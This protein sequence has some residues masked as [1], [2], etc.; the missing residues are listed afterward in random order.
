MSQ[1]LDNGGEGGAGGG[2]QPMD[3][4]GCS[5]VGDTRVDGEGQGAGRAD[6]A[7]VQQDGAAEKIQRQNRLEEDASMSPGGGAQPVEQLLSPEGVGGG[8]VAEAERSAR[9]DSP[10]ERQAGGRQIGAKRGRDKVVSGGQGREQRACSAAPTPPRDSRR[11]GKA[12]VDYLMHR[13]VCAKTCTKAV[14]GAFGCT[15]GT[16][17]F[18]AS[19]MAKTPGA[20][21]AMAERGAAER[22]EHGLPFYLREHVLPAHSEQALP[23]GERTSDSPPSKKPKKMSM[24]AVGKARADVQGRVLAK[25]YSSGEGQRQLALQNIKISASAIRKANKRAPGLAPARVGHAPA[26]PCAEE[27]RIVKW[28]HGM[29][30]YRVQITRDLLLGMVERWVRGTAFARCFKHGRPTAD[31]VR[32][33]KMRHRDALGEKCVSSLESVR[34]TY[35]PNPPS[36][37][38]SLPGSPEICLPTC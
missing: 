26:L 3:E 23:L 20:L 11:V 38:L 17:R 36:L 19:G 2:A 29:R 31:W 8:A 18:A 7:V 35:V 12:L 30:A 33:F 32:S 21:E 34:H 15:P 27:E 5:G 28:C 14:S 37:S 1:A 22:E 9:A 4:G 10:V 16:I 13:E 24:E 6:A 25:E